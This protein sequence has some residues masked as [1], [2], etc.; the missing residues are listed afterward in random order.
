[1]ASMEPLLICCLM[2]Q[3]SRKKGSPTVSCRTRSGRGER[4]GRIKGQSRGPESRLST[5]SRPRQAAAPWIF[6]IKK[7]KN[8]LARPWRQSLSASTLGF[9][10]R[11]RFLQKNGGRSSCWRPLKNS[12]GSQ[13][14]ETGSERRLRVTAEAVTVALLDRGDSRALTGWH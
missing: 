6:S 8:G 2:A 13:R 14:G 5:W 3:S 9:F 11:R 4:G 12:R 10:Q 1:M 7:K